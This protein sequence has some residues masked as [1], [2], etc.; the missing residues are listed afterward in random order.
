MF[1]TFCDFQLFM[2]AVWLYF[3][4]AVQCSA[5]CVCNEYN[6]VS[7]LRLRV[8][9]THTAER[10]RTYAIETPTGVD[11]CKFPNTI[12]L[13]TTRQEW[14]LMALAERMRARITKTGS[15][16]LPWKIV[17][18][19]RSNGRQRGKE[20]VTSWRKNWQ[21]RASL[22]VR[23]FLPRGKK[24]AATFFLGISWLPCYST[25]FWTIV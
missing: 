23:G 25:I 1:T 24:S 21:Q 11:T 18:S 9:T 16:V 15:N 17:A 22:E 3:S 4:S 13:V 6:F 14:T 8:Y 12:H 2:F 5:D 7:F 20:H 10:V 19:T